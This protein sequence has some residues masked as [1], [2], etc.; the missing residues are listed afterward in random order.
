MRHYT[1]WV[2]SHSFPAV[3]ELCFC[4]LYKRQLC[5]YLPRGV[6]ALPESRFLVSFLMKIQQGRLVRY[7]DFEPQSAA[8]VASRTKSFFPV[9]RSD[10]AWAGVFPR[11]WCWR[12]RKR[13]TELQIQCMWGVFTVESRSDGSPQGYNDN[14]RYPDSQSPVTCQ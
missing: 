13:S 14:D 1:A 8:G 7:T 5:R 4:C 3:V 9:P 6:R 10:P 2:C 11:H 12:L